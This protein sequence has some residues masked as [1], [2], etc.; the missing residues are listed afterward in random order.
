[1]RRPAKTRRKQA[2]KPVERPGPCRCQSEHPHPTRHLKIAAKVTFSNSAA[3]PRDSMIGLKRSRRQVTTADL[4]RRTTTDAVKRTR[5]A[6]GL[7]ETAIRG[8][9]SPFVV[10]FSSA[11]GRDYRR[12]RA[13]KAKACPWAGSQY[14][15]TRH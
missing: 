7:A 15:R 1:M 12:P 2:A 14:P 13:R 8:A 11:A 6:S 10:L 4:G 5:R 3:A 9:A